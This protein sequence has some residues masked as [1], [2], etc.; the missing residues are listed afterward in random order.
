MY[1][2]TLHSTVMYRL[3]HPLLLIYPIL[4]CLKLSCV[5]TNKIQ[6]PPDE[7]KIAYLSPK[8]IIQYKHEYF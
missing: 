3:C 2:H 5:S 8:K 4:N 6:T 7:L 1:L